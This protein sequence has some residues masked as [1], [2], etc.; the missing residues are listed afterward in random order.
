MGQH[1]MLQH[2]LNKDELEQRYCMKHSLEKLLN[3]YQI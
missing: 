3:I 2:I 1:A